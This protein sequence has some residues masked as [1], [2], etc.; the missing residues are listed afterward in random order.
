MHATVAASPDRAPQ[1]TVTGHKGSAATG[2][3]NSDAHITNTDA[4]ATATNVHRVRGQL[5]EDK[6][7]NPE[8]S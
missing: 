8:S 7:S 3:N 4:V 6:I 2:S 1:A 5:V